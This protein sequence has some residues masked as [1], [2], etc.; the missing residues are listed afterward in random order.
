MGNRHDTGVLIKK[1]RH[2]DAL[3]RF[4]EKRIL[5]LRKRILSFYLISTDYQYFKFEAHQLKPIYVHQQKG[6]LNLI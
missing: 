6:I 1:N 4:F 2:S 3:S 5:K